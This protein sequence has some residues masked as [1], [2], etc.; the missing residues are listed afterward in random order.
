MFFVGCQ[1]LLRV[2]TYGESRTRS[3]KV[4]L[5]ASGDSR[6]SD[7]NGSF[8]FLISSWQPAPLCLSFSHVISNVGS[9][10]TFLWQTFNRKKRCR[11]RDQAAFF[12]R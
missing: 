7:V 1:P 12:H 2:Q 4:D 5:R 9:L 6:W 3:E 10:E 8:A 11:P